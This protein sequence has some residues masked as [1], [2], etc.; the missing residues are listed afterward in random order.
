[1]SDRSLA[2]LLSPLKALQSLIDRFDSDGI[3]IGGVALSILAYPRFTADVDA[4]LLLPVERIDELLAAAEEYGCRPRIG[5]VKSFAR[6]HRVVLLHHVESGISIDISL[7][8]LPFEFEAV[9]GS[10]LHEIHGLNLRLP[11]VEDLIIMKAVAHRQKDLIDISALV[12]HH[13]EIDR[14]RIQST[15]MQFAEVLEMPELWTDIAPIFAH[16]G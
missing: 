5:D 9:R 12:E 2:H 13:S 1:M 3:I 4:M 7:G 14:A 8:I 6:K 10:K 11:S 15:V 16:K